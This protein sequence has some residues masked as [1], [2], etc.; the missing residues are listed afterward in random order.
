VHSIPGHEVY[1]W[2]AGIE[3]IGILPV[4]VTYLIGYPR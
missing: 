3:K 2:Q 4:G 1:E